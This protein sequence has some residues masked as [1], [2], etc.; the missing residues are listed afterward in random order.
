MWFAHGLIYCA[1]A[2]AIV[3]CAPGLNCIVNIIGGL[4]G[5]NFLYSL[6]GLVLGW[7]GAELPGE[8]FNPD[9]GDGGH[10]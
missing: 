6:P 5:V 7:L 10:T 1:R 2:F 4:L 9:T 3:A 8:G